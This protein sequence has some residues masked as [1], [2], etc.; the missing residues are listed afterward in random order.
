MMRKIVPVLMVMLPACAVGAE[1]RAAPEWQSLLEKIVNINSGS[2]NIEGLEAV[3]RV[4]IPEFE[5]LG[6]KATVHDVE[7]GHKV[8]S[9]AVSGSNPTLLLVGHIDTVF[10]KTSPFQKFEVRGNRI[11]GPGIIDM[12]A[13]VVMMLDLLKAFRGSGRL[14]RFLV[15]LNDDEETGS[16]FSHAL[17]R[18]LAGSVRAGLI[19]EPGLPGGAVVTAHSGVRWMTLSV[20]GKAAHA[21]LEPENGIN[22]CVELGHKVVALSKL[23]DHAR[24]LSVNVGVIEGGTKPNVVCEN[25]T[26][27]IDVRF[28]EKED[29]DRI[30][31]MI[32]DIAAKSYTYNDKLKAGPTATVK[33]L[34]AVPSMPGART[35]RLFGLLKIAGRKIGQTVS[36]RHVGYASDANQLAATGMDLLVGLGPYGKGMHTHTEYLTTATYDERLG[37][38]RALVE[39]ILKSPAGQ[40][41][42]GGNGGHRRCR[43]AGRR[44]KNSEWPWCRRYILSDARHVA[45]CPGAFDSPA[46]DPLD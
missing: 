29:A 32:R 10:P 42:D 44:V 1:A 35:R 14:K 19:F 38:T 28:V 2:R 27:R 45:V 17:I 15:I 7:E 23:S 22:A 3:R 31:K 30:D 11:Y 26:A 16:R 40:R 21:G 8:V 20:T 41:I 5:T 24:K 13:C 25:A 46:A 4:L 34:I 36:G 37:L 6:L 9:F 43:I 18:R 12:K 33:T 39:E